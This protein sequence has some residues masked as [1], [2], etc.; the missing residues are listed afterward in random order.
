M[1][2]LKAEAQMPFH[3]AVNILVAIFSAV[4]QNNLS[5]CTRANIGDPLLYVSL[6]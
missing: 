3:N 2:L 5:Y 1:L 4:A 6:G